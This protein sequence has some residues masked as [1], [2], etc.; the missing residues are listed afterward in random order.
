MYLLIAI[1]FQVQGRDPQ[2]ETTPEDATDER[3]EELSDAEIAPEPI[4]LPPC[5]LS[6]LEE[7]GEVFSSCLQSVVSRDKLAL[8]LEQEDYIHKLIELF[9]VCED[10]ENDGGLHQLYEIFKVV[11]LLNRASLC[12]VMF[13]DDVIFDVVG[14]LEYDPNKSEP[15]RHRDYLA[16]QACF[17]EVVPIK[18]ADLLARIHQTYRIQYVHDVILPTHSVFEE[19][20]LSSLSS[21]VFFNKVEIVAQLQVI[22]DFTKK[23]WC[24]AVIHNYCTLRKMM[25]FWM[26]C[27]RC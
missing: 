5:E 24:N 6:K 20:L 12:E 8:A 25:H 17:K 14:V 22:D 9:H 18:N 27:L 15:I 3:F 13:H 11:F 21:M 16:S 1:L 4:D 7:I 19:N 2:W 10:L 23:I 26:I